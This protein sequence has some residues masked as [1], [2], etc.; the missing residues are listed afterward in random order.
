MTRMS[1]CLESGTWSNAR[2]GLRELGHR[3][4]GRSA[5]GASSSL[6]MRLRSIREGIHDRTV[7]L[8]GS[9]K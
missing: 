7:V 5:T 9:F 2:P 8:S 1:L 3:L 4:Q 6:V